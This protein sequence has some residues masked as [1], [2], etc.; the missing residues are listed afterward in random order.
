MPEALGDLG[1]TGFGVLLAYVGMTSLGDE[2]IGSNQPD[3]FVEIVSP[4]I[5][6]F[7]ILSLDLV[8]NGSETPLQERIN[9]FI[10][11]EEQVQTAIARI[12]RKS[13]VSSNQCMEVLRQ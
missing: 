13:S 10:A 9:R 5:R 1:Q 4:I 6:E 7:G 8:M 11:M 12:C 2:V 3:W